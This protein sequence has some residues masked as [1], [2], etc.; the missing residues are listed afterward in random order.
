MVTPARI[1]VNGVAR[2]AMG[3]SHTCALTTDGAVYCFGGDQ[4]G[5][6]GQEQYE[7][8]AQPV[9]VGHLDKSVSVPRP[10]TPAPS[11]R[12]AMRC[13]GACPS[14]D[15]NASPAPSHLVRCPCPAPRARAVFAASYG[16]FVLG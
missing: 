11:C 6:V 1:A 10:G 16:T 8:Y 4:A 5:A 12:M 13:V 2:I 9:R 7:D 14:E 3:G 15:S